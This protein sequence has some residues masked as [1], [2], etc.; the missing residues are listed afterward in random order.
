MLCANEE[1]ERA[2]YRQWNH[3]EDGRHAAGEA[4]TQYQQE[5]PERDR[6]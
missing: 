4:Q 5:R 3:P 6:R 2:E 1:Q